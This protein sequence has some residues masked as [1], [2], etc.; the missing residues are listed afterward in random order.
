MNEVVSV[1][2][3]SYMVDLLPWGPSHRPHCTLS[4]HLGAGRA[5]LLEGRAQKRRQVWG[6]RLLPG[7]SGSA[8]A[9]AG[10]EY[11]HGQGGRPLGRGQLVLPLG[12]WQR[13]ACVTP[14]G[15]RN[16]PPALTMP[17]LGTD[18]AGF[19]EGSACLP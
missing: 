19:Q 16:V 8:S 17:A 11:S 3:G 14:G 4:V 9:K 6:L 12:S 5:A 18:A 10:T 2:K 15:R 13:E 7:T 1:G